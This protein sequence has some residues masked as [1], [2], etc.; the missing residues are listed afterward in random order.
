MTDPLVEY[1]CG[2]KKLLFKGILYT[3]IVEIK[4]SRC[5][6]ILV[7]V[8]TDNKGDKELTL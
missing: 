8:D 4:C 3:G 5:A 1:R 6:A 2:C 7:F